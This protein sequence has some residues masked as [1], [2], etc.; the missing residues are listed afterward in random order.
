MFADPTCVLVHVW[1]N[2]HLH[3][4]SKFDFLLLFGRFAGGFKR[5]LHR[6]E[7]VVVN[8]VREDTNCQLLRVPI[9][10]HNQ[11][12]FETVFR[13][14]RLW[15]PSLSRA[16][17]TPEKILGPSQTLFLVLDSTDIA[18]EACDPLNCLLVHSS[19]S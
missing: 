19:F 11:D 12:N 10:E 13:I 16:S 7:G 4:S 15:E 2:V 3:L 1:D 8:V 5:L 18:E 6:I 14:L 17:R 9:T